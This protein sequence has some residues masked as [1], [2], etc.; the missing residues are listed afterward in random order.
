MSYKTHCD[1][2][3]AS[4]GSTVFIHN[5]NVEP[6][7]FFRDLRPSYPGN[8]YLKPHLK[9]YFREAFSETFNLV[10]MLNPLVICSYTSLYFSIRKY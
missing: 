4:S 10:T 1:V 2:V 5:L 8:L 3:P 6:G 9:Y 7:M